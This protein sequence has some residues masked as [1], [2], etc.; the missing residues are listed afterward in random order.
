[1]AQTEEERRSEEFEREKASLALAAS[2]LS[3]YLTTPA[4]NEIRFDVRDS[5]RVIMRVFPRLQRPS[6]KRYFATIEADG[7]APDRSTTAEERQLG[8][9]SLT[10]PAVA[11]DSLDKLIEQGSRAMQASAF[12]TY[13]EMGPGELAMI[14]YRTARAIK[15]A[16]RKLGED[17]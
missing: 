17:V 6:M 12:L 16:L 15:T 9:L 8:I 4:E 10:P 1:M 3:L 2:Q 13:P 7:L 5:P 14:H 11:T